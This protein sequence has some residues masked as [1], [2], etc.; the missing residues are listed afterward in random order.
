LQDFKLHC[1]EYST[2]LLSVVE[3]ERFSQAEFVHLTLSEKNSQRNDP[4][5]LGANMLDGKKS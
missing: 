2:G 1:P 4:R 5:I 3:G